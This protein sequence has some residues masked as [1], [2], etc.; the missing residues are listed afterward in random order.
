MPRPSLLGQAG[1]TLA[2]MLVATAVMALTASIAIPNA[3]P[4]VAINKDATTTE[5]IRA[6]RFAQ[7]EAIRT[8]AWH[9]VRID[10]TTQTLRVYRM[11]MSGTVSE[12]T[13]IPVL[14]PID[15]RK[16]DQAFG[17]G[18]NAPGTI[19]LVDFDYESG[20]NTNL[21][22]LSFGPDGTPGLLTGRKA[23]DVKS[24]QA[25][26]VSIRYGSQQRDLAIDVVTGR[27]S[28]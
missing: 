2:E 8:G 25:G 9:T 10:T 4:L 15:K 6:I 16:Y 20:G 3:A 7:R 21:N 14:H 23:G 27:V 26:K 19:A 13:S 11:T 18:S 17:A 1:V 22:T 5:I 24:M 28:G 12:D